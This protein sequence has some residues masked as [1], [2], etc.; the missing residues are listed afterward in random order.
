MTRV[1]ASRGT[2]RCRPY[3]RARRES[4]PRM[5]SFPDPPQPAAYPCHSSRF[6]RNRV[7][8]LDECRTVTCCVQRV[9]LQPSH[10]IRA[11]LQESI[12]TLQ[13]TVC[14]GARWNPRSRTDVV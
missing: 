10:T 14:D 12:A 7:I 2:L 4:H 8:H 1:A 11:T 5:A 9:G 3:A 6:L 13:F